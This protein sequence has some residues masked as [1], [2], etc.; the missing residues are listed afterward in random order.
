[1]S[2]VSSNIQYMC[3]RLK[4]RIK[5]KFTES[6]PSFAPNILTQHLHFKTLHQYYAK[7]AE[8]SH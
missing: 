7:P 2:A 1:M 5:T 8:I 3:M 4:S 6:F